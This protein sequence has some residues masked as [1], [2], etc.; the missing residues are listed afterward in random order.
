MTTWP[1]PRDETPAHACVHSVIQVSVLMRDKSPNRD[2]EYAGELVTM[3]LDVRAMTSR[4]QLLALLT[5]GLTGCTTQLVEP[6]AGK[7][8]EYIA[9][10]PYL[11]VDDPKVDEGPRSAEARE[12]DYQCSTQNLMETR[13][14][15]R[16]VAYA[17]NSD[18]L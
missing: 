16:I 18:A 9:S 2:R 6:E 13:Q 14:Y 12:G 4:S 10:L 8:D 11:P 15:D 3:L 5:V 1:A 17:A 7:I